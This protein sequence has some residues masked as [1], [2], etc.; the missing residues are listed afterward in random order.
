MV[1]FDDS[2]QG[3]ALALMNAQGGARETLLQIIWESDD[4]R[5]MQK[6]LDM[7]PKLPRWWRS[8]FRNASKQASG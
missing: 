6:T 7:F 3:D 5:M 4:L 1:Y 2:P 8:R